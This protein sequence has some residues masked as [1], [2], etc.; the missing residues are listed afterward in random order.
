MSNP[1]PGLQLHP[2]LIWNTLRYD[3]MPFTTIKFLPGLHPGPKIQVSPPSMYCITPIH[4]ESFLPN[5]NSCRIS[6][7][8]KV[9]MY[10]SHI[11][12][13]HISDPSRSRELQLNT[14]RYAGLTMFVSAPAILAPSRYRDVRLTSIQ[15]LSNFHP[16]PL[17][18]ISTPHKSHLTSS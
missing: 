2:G 5:F 1:H 12:P 13:F 6:N 9:T 4:A 10:S 3:N 8:N 18:C 14:S 11:N 15:L 7:P 17:I 16:G